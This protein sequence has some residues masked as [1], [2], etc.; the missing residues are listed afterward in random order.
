MA[1][2]RLSRLLL[3]PSRLDPECECAPPMQSTLFNSLVENGKAQAA[4]YPFCT[5]EPNT[6]MV[7]VPD[8]RLQV[9]DH[10]AHK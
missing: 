1:S 4:N 9:C 2:G 7:T 8:P 10:G 5:I 6:G 3:P